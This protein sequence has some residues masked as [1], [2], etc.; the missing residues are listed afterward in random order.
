MVREVRISTDSS[1][2]RFDVPACRDSVLDEDLL[3]TIPRLSA[4]RDKR[5]AR[6]VKHT[7]AAPGRPA[8]ERRHLAGADWTTGELPRSRRS[9]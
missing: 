1:D 7:P 6:P 2:P 3:L 5:P 8:T 9:R 4:Q